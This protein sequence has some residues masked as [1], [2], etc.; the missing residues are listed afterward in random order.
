MVC[1]E[2]CVMCGLCGRVCG[3]KTQMQTL[4]ASY[5]WTWPLSQKQIELCDRKKTCEMVWPSVCLPDNWR[6]FCPCTCLC[7]IMQPTVWRSKQIASESRGPPR[8]LLTNVWRQIPGNVDWFNYRSRSHHKGSVE[9]LSF[10]FSWRSLIEP[11]NRQV[12]IQVFR[13]VTSC[14]LVPLN[15][16]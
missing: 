1:V 8:F 5:V 15:T 10:H 14:R 6:H 12:K 13:D 3:V 9:D 2:G 7:L 16:A 4:I 11:D